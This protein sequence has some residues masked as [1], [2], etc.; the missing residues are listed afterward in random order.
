MFFPDCAKPS[1]KLQPLGKKII[2]I[3]CIFYTPRSNYSHLLVYAREGHPLSNGGH[4]GYLTGLRV[5]SMYVEVEKKNIAH[6]FREK[7]I[8]FSRWLLMFFF[9]T[10]CF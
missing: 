5:E 8:R 3:W 1:R 6:N 9:T 2:Y 4:H 10:I 7:G